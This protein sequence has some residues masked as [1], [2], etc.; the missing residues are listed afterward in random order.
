MFYRL[1][2]AKPDDTWVHQP[3]NTQWTS[4]SWGQ[5]GDM[6]RRIAAGLSALELPK[7]SKIAILSKNSIYWYLCD[8][9]I[10]MSGHVSVPAFT[11]MDAKGTRYLLDNSETKAMFIGPADNWQ[12]VADVI[13]ADITLIS[14]PGVSLDNEYTSLEAMLTEHEPL[15]SDYLPQADELCTIIY[16]S[17]TT[18]MPKGVMHSHGSLA[19]SGQSMLNTYKTTEADRFISF[20]PLSHIF[21]RAVLMQSL[22]CGGQVFFN[23]SLETFADDMLI[24]NPTW[25]CAPPRI[26]QKFQQSIIAKIGAEKLEAMLANT[27]SSVHIKKNQLQTMVQESMGLSKAR[28]RVTGGGQTPSELYGWYQQLGMP[29]YDIYGMTEAAPTATNLPEANKTGTVGRPVVGAEVKIADNGEILTRTPC[30]MMGYYNDPEKSKEDLAGGWMHTGDLGEIDEDGY[31]RVTGRIKEIFKTAK[32]KYVAPTKVENKMSNTPFVEN[33]CLV[34]SGLPATILLVNL[35]EDGNE[36][37]EG[38]LKSTLIEKMNTINTE[39]EKHERMSHIIVTHETWSIQNSLLTH[40]T[41]IKRNA[42]ENKYARI[43]QEV[44]NVATNGSIVFEAS[45]EFET[46]IKKEAASLS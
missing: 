30:M 16:T 21:E 13:P 23:Q 12:D 15:Q 39:L 43:V 40:T 37:D 42:I 46:S 4:Y 35:T 44:N 17:G 7:G 25:F 1:E 31:L 20:L 8:L 36:I 38:L 33:L 45:F 5:A 2:K 27:D 32:G 22:A 41:K 9:A 10:M 28:I 26:W 34:G 19:R 24:A 6:V 11:T 3:D 29:L 18:G 14:M